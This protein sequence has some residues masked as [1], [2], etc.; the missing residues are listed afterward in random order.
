MGDTLISTEI[1]IS[2]NYP[3][4]GLWDK[5]QLVVILGRTKRD[6]NS[7]FVGNKSDT[8]D[9]LKFILMKKVQW[10]EY[11]YHVLELITVNCTQSET[12]QGEKWIHQII[13]QEALPFRIRDIPLPQ[14]RTGCVY[15]F[16]S[17]RTRSYSYIRTANFILI[18]IQEHNSGHGSKSTAPVYRPSFPVMTYI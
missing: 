12:R 7:I 2:K 8:L 4:F 1:Q 6:K 16:I 17:F 13:S 9:A 11:I 14:C 15:I 10:C 18:I 3:Q 5:V